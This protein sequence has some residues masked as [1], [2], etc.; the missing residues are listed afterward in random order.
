MLNDVSSQASFLSE[1]TQ[2]SARPRTRHSNRQKKI[3]VVRPFEFVKQQPFG[4]PE[5][6]ELIENIDKQIADLTQAVNR[7]PPIVSLS[8]KSIQMLAA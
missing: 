1:S 7:L 5:T 8:E 3:T 6:E 4:C 2:S